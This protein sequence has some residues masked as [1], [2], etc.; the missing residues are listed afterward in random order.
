MVNRTEPIEVRVT[1]ERKQKFTQEM[2]TVVFWASYINADKNKIGRTLSQ[3]TSWYPDIKWV[4]DEDTGE[5]AYYHTSE[6]EQPWLDLI[7]VEL[8]LSLENI[9]IFALPGVN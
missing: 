7:P 5:L 9:F 1:P 3:A 8:L 2:S 4:Y 6:A